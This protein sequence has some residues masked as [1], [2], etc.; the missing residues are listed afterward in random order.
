MDLIPIFAK[1]RHFNLIRQACGLIL[2]ISIIFALSSG[3]LC[4]QQIPLDSPFYMIDIGDFQAMPGAIA[5]MPVQIK[6][7]EA[8]GAAI[9]RLV[10]DT[11]VLSPVRLA[12]GGVG[13]GSNKVYDS[14]EL[15]GR[16][17]GSTI[18][19][20]MNLF[21]PPSPGRTDTAYHMWAMHDTLDDSVNG[22]A[23]FVQ[24]IPPI[25]P[26]DT[27]L[28]KYF[29]LPTI[30]IKAD[31]V[32][33]ILYLLFTVNPN[34]TVGSSSTVYVQNYTGPFIGDSVPRNQL[35]NDLGTAVFYPGKGTGRFTVGEPLPVDPCPDDTCPDTCCTAGPPGNHAP[36]VAAIVP[37]AYEIY[38]GDS[39]KFTVSATD[40]DGDQ[41][42]L[43]ATGLP[44][45]ASFLPSNP[46]TGTSSVSGNFRFV[47][48]FAQSGNFTIDF[49]AT[50]EHS[51]ASG[52]RT[53]SINVKVLDIDRL[54][55]TST[56][57]GAPAGGIPGARDI[58]FPIDLSTSKTV[59]GVQFDM[60][61]P[62]NIA[63]IDSM[64]V[65][66]RTP[67][68]VVYENIGQFPDAVRVVTFGLDNEQVLPGSSSAILNAY[69]KIDSEA[70]A[71]DYWIHLFDAW[72]SIDPNP[73][74]PSLTLRTDS[75]IVQVDHFGDVNLDKYVNVADLVN[76]VAY[77]VGTY[78]L[79]P[80]NFATADVVRDA[81]VNVIDLVGIVN[82]I[83]GLPVNPSPV[84][85][86]NNDGLFA[87]LKI[88]HD[89]LS[90]GQLTKLNVRGEFPDDIAGVQMQIDYDPDAIEIDRPELAEAS[91]GFFLAYNNDHNG[92]IRMVLY[93]R[94]P[95]KQDEL[96]QAGIGDILRLPARI[97]QNISADDKSQIRIT[98]ATLSSPNAKGIPVE[99]TS[100][101]LPS[102]FTLY[103]NYPN[104]FNPTTRIEFDIKHEGGGRVENAELHI[105]NILGQHIRTLVDGSVIAGRHSIS[106]DAT[107]DSGRPVSTG[108]YLYRLQVGDRSQTRKMLLLK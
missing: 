76:V 100:P 97:K 55:S 59:Y 17:W 53:V 102:T 95:W 77:I 5:K 37:S 15:T 11:T 40:Q 52:I 105:Y 107:D 2:M 22:N 54:F 67:E 43:Q 96:I 98:E 35:S 70:T 71:G 92:R 90:A 72:E 34:A 13:G 108:I 12:G 88:E 106:W 31:T 36:V 19:D 50:D 63:K 23:I 82:L 24:F 73:A 58:I 9:L 14:L 86:N 66:D 49:Q 18:I 78:G 4:A 27:A 62:G 91:G 84:Q 44:A 103:Q 20:S 79:P 39:V 89:D 61:Y 69:L 75:G 68:Y 42:S 1:Y 33:A 87:T 28:Y 38:Q 47:P 29:E 48:S 45:N 64:V 83:F 26:F 101:A 85:N 99:G 8:V 80:R 57:G 56:Y 93:S 51:S 6:N 46:V 65:T 74:I 30:A 10:Y 16:G 21:Y 32:S 94:E 25:P 7:E 3:D 60:T 104:P 81:F 41:L